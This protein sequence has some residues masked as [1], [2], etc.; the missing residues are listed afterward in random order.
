[1]NPGLPTSGYAWTTV[2]NSGAF[3]N[4]TYNVGTDNYALISGTNAGAIG[5]GIPVIS[6]EI[7]LTLT[8]FQSG[9][10]SLALAQI[11]GVVFTWNSTGQFSAAGIPT[12]PE[13][14]TVGMVGMALLGAG[15]GRRFLRRMWRD[16]NSMTSEPAR[17]AGQKH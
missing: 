2:G 12:A 5:G 17:S 14:E 15:M 11:N 9:G 6:N 16:S 13:P 10:V 7:F 4:G 1:V 8:G 3:S